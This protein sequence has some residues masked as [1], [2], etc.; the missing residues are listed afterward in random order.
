MSERPDPS[1]DERKTLLVNRNELLKAISVHD[2]VQVAKEV[3]AAIA[4][5]PLA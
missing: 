2:A 4:E 5:T 3:F 1:T